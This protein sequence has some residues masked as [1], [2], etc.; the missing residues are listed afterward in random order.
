MLY[1]LYVFFTNY[2][3]AIGIVFVCFAIILILFMKY[4]KLWCKVLM[5]VFSV[6]F[7]LLSMVFIVEHSDD[8]FFD[9]RQ[10][11]VMKGVVLETEDGMKVLYNSDGVLSVGEYTGYIDVSDYG[12][13][14]LDGVRDFK[15]VIQQL[16]ND[17]DFKSGDIVA[18][19]VKKS[20]RSS[21]TEFFKGKLVISLFL[22][23]DLWT[24]AWYPMFVLKTGELSD[25]EFSECVNNMYAGDLYSCYI[26]GYGSFE[27]P[28]DYEWK[29]VEPMSD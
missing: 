29:I 4:K 11:G 3:Y 15:Y 25:I 6:I 17:C 10:Y 20:M 7:G 28:F 27:V 13:V 8:D 12:I 5:F 14:H 16:S 1:L 23:H 19:L 9:Y 18:V 24:D 26:P 21:I 2:V 22:G